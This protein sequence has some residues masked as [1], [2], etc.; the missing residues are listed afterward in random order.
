MNTGT[1]LAVGAALMFG[2]AQFLNAVVSARLPGIAVA[3]WTLAS[4]ALVTGLATAVIRPGPPAGSTMWALLAGAGGALG[5]AALY[6]SL[7]RGNVSMAIPLCT[8][9]TTAIPVAVGLL[10]LGEGGDASTALGLVAALV[11]IILV[12]RSRE[13]TRPSPGLQAAS[14]RKPATAEVFST[15]TGWGTA[16]LPLLAGIGF[17][18][19]LIGISRFPSDQVISLLWVSFVVA[20]LLLLPIRTPGHAPARRRD[21]AAVIA[22]GALTAAA[23]IAFHRATELTGLSVAGIIVSL[24]PVVPVVLAV[25]LL[26][27][28]PGPGRVLGLISAAVAVLTIGGR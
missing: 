17:A 27:E 9:T 19:E 26:G 14:D 18:V 28:R 5:A 20:V 11:A 10:F 12:S 6:R 24:Y 22:A 21:I 4:A 2:A 1:L 3:R 8:T 15:A 13:N 23:M 7:E 25:A 16:G